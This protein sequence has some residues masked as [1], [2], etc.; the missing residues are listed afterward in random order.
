MLIFS[1]AQLFKC[2]HLK[3]TNRILTTDSAYF[4]KQHQ[5]HQSKNATYLHTAEVLQLMNTSIGQ[6]ISNML[7]AKQAL[8]M[9][10]P[11][12]KHLLL[13]STE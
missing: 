13:P 1:K 5:I 10:F 8:P 6:T 9:G 3:I 2:V 4:M 12:M 11:M 7:S